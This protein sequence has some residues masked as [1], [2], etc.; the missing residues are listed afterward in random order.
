MTSSRFSFLRRVRIHGGECGA[1][2]RALHHEVKGSSLYQADS[3][4]AFGSTI[5]RKQMSTKTTLKR[6]ALVA[7]S[8]MGFGLVSSV[9]PV[10]AAPATA[11]ASAFGSYTTVGSSDL[12]VIVR[13]TVKDSVGAFD[14]LSATTGETMAA[15]VLGAMPNSV[16]T[17]TA[18]TAPTITST[19]ATGTSLAG[20]TASNPATT[21]AGGIGV[22]NGGDSAVQYFKIAGSASCLDAGYYTVRFTTYEDSGATTVMG[23][24]DVK[25]G[26]VNNTLGLSGA[27]ITLTSAATT[28]TQDDETAFG[29]TEAQLVTVAATDANGGVI[30]SAQG[31][32]P[33]IFRGAAYVAT[34]GRLEYVPTV[35]IQWNNATTATVSYETAVPSANFADDGSTNADV[36]LNDG[37]YS[38]KWDANQNALGE[39]GLTTRSIRAYFGGNT[40]VT[41]SLTVL[42]PTAS[43][44]AVFYSVTATGKFERTQGTGATGGSYD[45][46][47]STKSA[48]ATVYVSASS[49]A[50]TGYSMYYTVDYSG[51]VAGDM[52]PVEHTSSAAPTKVLTDAN[53]LASA[54]ITHA[55]PATGCAAT[56]TWTG[57]ATNLT[58][59]TVITWKESTP[60][61]I[62]SDPGGN[63]QAKLLATTKVT[64]TI[65]DQ[66][67]A[68]VVGKSVTLTMTG[69]NAPD[70]GIA[71]KITDANGQ[72]SYEW[73]DAAAAAAD[74][75]AIYVSAVGTTAFTTTTGGRVVV[76][77]KTTLDTISTLD[78]KYT[79]SAVTTAAVIPA[80]AIGGASGRATSA[81][82]QLDS[83][84]NMQA[85]VD[86][87]SSATYWVK[88][89]VTHLK[90]DG[91]TAVS[92]IPTTVTV[93]GANLLS[94]AGKYVTTRTIYGT[95]TLT[96]VG[97][98]SGTA[99]VTFVNGSLTKTSTIN[100]VNVS[101]DARVLALTEKDGTV[102]A[103]VTD[104][105]GSPV[106]DVT[107]NASGSGTV[108]F[109]NSGSATSFV[110]DA[111][112]SVSFTVTGEGTVTASLSTTS[113]AKTAY[114]ADSGNATGTVSTP[115]APAGVRSA[116]V[117]TKGAA[118]KQVA[119]SNAATAAAE[120][121][122]DAA[123]EAIDAANAATDAANLAAEAADAATVAAEEARDA[124]DAATA[125]VEA[126]A[127]EVATLI[128]SLKA[129]IT[130]LANTV[131]KIAK[132]VKA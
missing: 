25:F 63:I 126:L 101:G 95:S 51:C 38:L 82:D 131:A 1:V 50:L 28:A 84:R 27:T 91:V 49:A 66:Y 87:A 111:N 57:A 123:L 115:G 46:P 29:G 112:G 81:A 93:T 99:T 74:T 70:A 47:L 104:F 129:Q 90:S 77:Y 16:G 18:C 80:T 11:V 132:K 44:S 48:T 67:G 54:T 33:A 86:A 78:V 62:V 130:T 117:T 116:S 17:T 124:A 22:G 61:T 83:S 94:S 40:K 7:V 114:L 119:A 76:T 53:G 41:K 43:S 5:E 58:T 31:S 52:S 2:A 102:T 21:F 19:N 37:V 73:T 3:K 85:A 105:A 88:Y 71:S 128:A 100:F 34:G 15:S 39:R 72:V 45:V 89:T 56:I 32:K 118:D 65:V 30:I 12:T 14:S 69:E 110:T 125:A 68:A 79:T 6:I 55:N 35:D 120:A 64:W 13:L 127:S 107:V 103:T 42:A 26:H 92:G 23:Y 121:A 113:Y 122:T 60:T 106:A 8:A 59:D 20:K 36:T 109:G 9:A 108:R 98:K 10:N 24:K 4:K 96:V 75:D 97:T